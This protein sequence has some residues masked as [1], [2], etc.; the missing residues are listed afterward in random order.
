MRC[1]LWVIV[2]L[3]ST[4]VAGNVRAEEPISIGSRLELLVD[5]YL[6]D[7]IGGGAR[8]ELHRPTRREIVFKTDAPWEG[9]ASAFQSVFKDGALYRMYYRGLHYADGGRAAQAKSAHPWLLCYAESDD[10]LRWRRP[11]LGLFEFNGSKA[12]NII[13]TPEFLAEIGGDPAQ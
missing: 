12:N 1:R 5:D 13:L 7:T 10:G 2:V 11:K 8:L 3:I 4:V 6:I 9:N